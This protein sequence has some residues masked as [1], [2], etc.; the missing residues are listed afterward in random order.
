MELAKKSK[1]FIAVAIILTII[2]IV[3]IINRSCYMESE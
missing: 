2:I 1:I 3:G